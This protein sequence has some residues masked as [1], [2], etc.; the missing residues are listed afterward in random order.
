MSFKEVI[1]LMLFL[2][3]QYLLQFDAFLICALQ[4]LEAKPTMQNTKRLQHYLQQPLY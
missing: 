1:F 4:S 3:F 2:C